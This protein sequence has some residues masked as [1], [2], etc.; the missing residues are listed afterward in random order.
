MK[1]IQY[2]I[3]SALG[4][5]LSVMSC[6]RIDIVETPEIRVTDSS[7]ELVVSTAEVNQYISD[8]SYFEYSASGDE[9][10]EVLAAEKFNVVSN[11]S[12]RV[13]PVEEYDWI[14][15]YPESGDKEGVFRFFVERNNSQTVERTARFEVYISDGQQERK[16]DGLITV[17]QGKCV[18][19]MKASSAG[20]EI[21]SNDT[22]KKTITITCNVPWEYELV[23]DANY[24]TE[25]LDWLKDLTQ[26]TDGVSQKIVLQATDN[27]DGVIRGA[28][29]KVSAPQYPDSEEFNREIPIVQLGK[30]VE[31]NG[32]P[33]QW[34]IGIGNTADKINFLETFPGSGYIDAVTGGGRISYVCPPDK[35]DPDGK[36]TRVVGGGGDPY[37]TG[38]WPGDYWEFKSD[39]PVSGGTILKISFEAATSAT[40]QKFWR[41]EYKDGEDWYVPASLKQETDEPGSHIV[42]THTM[43]TSSSDKVQVSA[44]VQIKNTTD[45]AH[46]RFVCAANWQSNGSGPLDAPN[47]GTM[48]LSLSDTKSTEWQ[49]TIKCVAAGT[50]DLTPATIEVTG[51]EDGILT[52]EGTPES[53]KTIKVTSDIDFETT[54]SVSWLHV[55]NGS[56][57][58]FETRDVVITCDPSDLPEMRKGQILVKSGITTYTIN[59]IQ[60]AAG[61]ELEPFISIVGG[62]TLSVPGTASEL[63][64]TVQA[65]VEFLTEIISEGLWITPGTSPSSLVEKT[66]VL[67]NIAENKGTAE[68]TG[69]IRFYNEKENI[70]S[71]ITIKQAP[72]TIL[73][74]KWDLSEETMDTYN[75]LFSTEAGDAAKIEGFGGA[76][77]PANAAG[78][79]SIKYYSI[80]KTELD[81]NSKFER[82]TGGTGEPY[83][84]GAWPGDYWLISAEYPEGIPDGAKIHVSFISRASGTGMKYWLVEYYDGGQWKP[85]MEV[86]TA[87]VEGET[88]QYN[89]NHNNTANF[90]VD[91][92]YIATASEE[93]LIR[94]TC[95]ANAQ[96]SGK[97]PLEAPNGGTVR[98]KG[99]SDSPVIEMFR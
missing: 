36:F 46:F 43:K 54:S 8:L 74:A 64:L 56:G 37:V 2:I 59:V 50:E 31:I 13:V 23:P 51:L 95:Q 15:T 75:K 41:L 3:F 85:A 38:A 12:W 20:L 69:K 73:L 35:A 63:E 62:N 34:I 45:A 94:I 78:T 91:F 72:G 57:L 79:G 14:R 80:D 16:V 81:V 22:G 7:D 92:S 93:V 60:S 11:T 52:F 49:P 88:I 89:I 30:D 83:V 48:R 58:S 32:F 21:V 53:G 28:L 40:G 68:R 19:F 24:A 47:G 5:L 98:L 1:R 9:K 6:E 67:F 25:N 26:K 84:T 18:D 27:S 65:N 55:E 76:Y 87:E 10:N 96:A 86:Q 4:I 97:G 82:V 71:V 42:Y 44:T 61:A 29:L 33:V 99:G 39:A 77:L 90:D 70:E 17:N 66:P